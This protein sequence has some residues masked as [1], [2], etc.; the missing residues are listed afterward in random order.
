MVRAT[1]SRTPAARPERARLRA[2]I[3]RSHWEAKATAPNCPMWRLRRAQRLDHPDPATTAHLIPRT[4]S[5]SER[6]PRQIVIGR[7]LVR[8][9]EHVDPS[10]QRRSLE[11]GAVSELQGIARFKFHEGKLEEFKRLATQCMEIVRAKDTGTLPSEDGRQGGPSLHSLPVD[12][13]T[14]RRLGRRLLRAV[15]AF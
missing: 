2:A 14:A 8:A 3:G 5:E 1:A 4:I 15:A 13:D 9:T 6:E 11:A 7:T 10:Q 12:V